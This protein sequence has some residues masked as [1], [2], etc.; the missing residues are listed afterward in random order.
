[1]KRFLLALLL[2]L[3]A[4]PA[5]GADMPAPVLKA[6][7]AAAAWSGFYL[8]GFAAGAKTD[9]NFSFLAVPGTGNV[10]PSGGMAGG[11]VGVGTWLGAIYVG[12]EADA[13]W[14]FTKANQ[15]CI[16]SLTQCKTTSGFFLTQRGIVGVTLP[17]LASAAAARGITAPA[18]WPVPLNVPTS[19]YS[20]GLLPYLTGG[21][22][23]RRLEAEVV[24]V[25]KNEEWLIGAVAGGGL[26]YVVSSGLS[27]KAEYLFVNWNK[28]FNPAG[29][30][31][32]PAD[33]KAQNEQVLRF[34]LDF[35]L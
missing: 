3:F 4:V 14:D 1:M 24:G 7:A 33:F 27:V 15:P 5:L 13:A 21:I 25:G 23:E 17:G 2:A 26:K 12:A 20:G 35:H 30:A 16:F 9:A 22:A 10:R 19:V 11:G 18:Q 6:P 28:H 8:T 31:V 29:A 32:F 34:G